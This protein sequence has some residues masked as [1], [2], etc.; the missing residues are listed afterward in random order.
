MQTRCLLKRRLL[1]QHCR[2]SLT[3]ARTAKEKRLKK[4]YTTVKPHKKNV[5]AH[6]EGLLLGVGLALPG[7]ICIKIFSKMLKI[8]LRH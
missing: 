6:L 4:T 3:L 8:I 5:K 1:A 7:K 2:A